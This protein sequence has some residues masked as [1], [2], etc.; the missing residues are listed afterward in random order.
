MYKYLRL[1]VLLLLTGSMAAMTLAQ[2]AAPAAPVKHYKADFV[3]REVDGSGHVVN[4]R[5]FSTILAADDQGA[6]TEIRS[7]DKVPVRTSADEK[8][9]EVKY[10][11]ID[12]GVNIDCQHVRE[13]DQKLALSIRAEVSSASAGADQNSS[14]GPLI[15]QFKWNADVLIAPGVPTTI[16]SSDDMSSKSKMV[17][18]VTATPVR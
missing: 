13:V 9:D 14:L 8:G 6:P 1:S 10:Q 4:S 2:A 3:V 15:R 12:L 18:E 11:Y 5:S 16:F 7:G 17:F